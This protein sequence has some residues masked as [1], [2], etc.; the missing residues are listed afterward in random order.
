[1][2]VNAICQILLD[3]KENNIRSPESRPGVPICLRPGVNMSLP[4][5]AGRRAW[6]TDVTEGNQPRSTVKRPDNAA[7]NKGREKEG[8]ET[9]K[10]R[11][12]EKRRRTNEEKGR[13]L[14]RRRRKN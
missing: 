6:V 4:R 8:D 12:L 10:E 14:G 3:P 7:Q 5:Q 13:R 2:V 11:R 9:E 1:M